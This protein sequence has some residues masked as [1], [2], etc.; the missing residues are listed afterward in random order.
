MYKEFLAL[1][2]RFVLSDDSH[3]VAHVGLHYDKVLDFVR[4]AGIRELYFVRAS[5]SARGLEEGEMPSLS[6]VNLAELEADPFWTA[7]A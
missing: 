4:T 5:P 3:G 6:R 2:G 7:V 1:G